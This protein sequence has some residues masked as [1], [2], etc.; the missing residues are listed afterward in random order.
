MMFAG[1]DT[2]GKRV[3]ASYSLIGTAKLNGI[4]PEAWLRHVQA[5]LATISSTVL[6]SFHPAIAP[7]GWH[8]PENTPLP[9]SVMPSSVNLATSSIRRKADA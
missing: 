8:L 2:G 3:T 7:G 1:A 5:R 9:G 6:T 4:D